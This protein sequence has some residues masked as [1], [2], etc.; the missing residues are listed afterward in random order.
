MIHVEAS[1]QI[2][3]N[4]QIAIID[5]NY[6][7]NDSIIDESIPLAKPIH[8]FEHFQ[9]PEPVLLLVFLLSALLAPFTSPYILHIIDL[10]IY[11]HIII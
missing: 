8:H 3:I 6:I 11:N 10:I 1:C 5:E 4:S 2:P 7:H 9:N